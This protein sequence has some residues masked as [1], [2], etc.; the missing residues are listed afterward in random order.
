M[1]CLHRGGGGSADFFK[2]IGLN[3]ARSYTDFER[4]EIGAIT[5]DDD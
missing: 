3:M 5:A 4:P 1:A 2:C